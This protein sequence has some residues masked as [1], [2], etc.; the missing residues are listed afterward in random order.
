[1]TRAHTK[2]I[3]GFGAFGTG[4]SSDEGTALKHTNIQLSDHF[5]YRRLLRFTFPS[6]A[7]MLFTSI[8]GIVD[9]FFVSNYV[10]A[11]PFA[12]LNLIFPFLMLFGAIGFM[13]GAGGT[14]LVSKTLGEG[15]KKK[16]NEIFSLL[17][18]L[19][20]AVGTALSV[21]GFCFMEKAALLLGAD[22]KMLPYCVIYGRIIIVGMVPFML[23]NVFQSFL[24]TAERPKF[25]L[26][27]TVATGVSNIVL[28]YLFMGVF[29][30]GI[31]GAAAATTLSQFLGGVI[32]LI[33][34]LAP[35]KSL[36]RLGITHMDWRAVLKS[37]TN[38]ASE[39]MSNV[40]FSFITILYNFQLMKFA[41]ENGVAAFGVLMYTNFI[42]M[43]VFIGY[44][45]G[46]APLFG[47]NYGAKND[48]ELHNLFKKSLIMLTLA[49]L[50]LTALSILAATPLSKLYV[51]Y[52]KELFELTRRG[53]IIYSFSFLFCGYNV[54]SSSFFTALNNGLISALISFGRTL[55]F[56]LL[57]I[58][59]L[60][61][62]FGIDGVWA[63]NVLAELL[64]LCVCAAFVLTQRKK[65]RY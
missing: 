46:S 10:G 47:Y 33:Y 29:H 7:M 56:Q 18:Y 52:D 4:K 45:I 2:N 60:P 20:I 30:R 1:M 37:C 15:D 39:F 6:V 36:L 27:I 32:P 48:A 34:F 26:L 19:L 54:L 3:I 21:L 8:Y 58:M 50:C 63:A 61:L 64:A 44:A 11:T 40:S 25:G 62:F 23:Q 5:N 16:A 55:V 49:S 38:G 24:V 41:G 31:E 42:F 14:A 53:Y 12:A 51:G 65:Y 28:D 35:N 22:E 9:G 13:T 57:S 59:L 17:I 43:S